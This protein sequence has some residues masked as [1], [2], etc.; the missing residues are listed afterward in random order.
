MAPMDVKNGFLHVD[1]QEE[2]YMDLPQDFVA[3]GQ[4]EKVCHL[5]KSLYG[6]KQSP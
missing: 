3:K 6:L 4:E 1:L 2:V 5:R